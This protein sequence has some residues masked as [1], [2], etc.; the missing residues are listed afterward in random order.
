MKISSFTH[1]GMVRNNNEDSCLVIPPWS[2][3]SVEK[4]VCV[5]AV[6]DGMGGQNAGEVASGLAV[7]T[8]IEWLESNT[9]DQLSISL[10]EDLISQINQQIWSYAQRNPEA[11][12]MGTTYTMVIIKA[13]DAIVGH[14][15]D[16]RLYRYR[17]DKLEQMTN[18]HSLVAEQVKSGKLSLEQARI[19]PTR[20]ILSRVLGARQF[21]VPDIFKLDLNQKDI[22]LIC[23]DGV[24]G[25]I[26]DKE[27]AELIKN[28]DLP[29]LAQAVVEAANAG[30]GKDN[31]TAVAFCIDQLPFVI[32]GRFSLDRLRDIISHWRDAG[33]I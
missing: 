4:G 33:A 28:V 15:G 17:N 30:G 13:S 16:S 27:I 32:P 24:N 5:F 11:A 10:V 25:M 1:S 23:S 6:A 20:H 26:E 18:D 12:G 9:I 2:S 7:K 22:F 8:T 21:V 19:H 14:I 29:E 31:C 3:L